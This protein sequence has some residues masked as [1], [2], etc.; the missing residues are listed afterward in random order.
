VRKS[1]AVLIAFAVALAGPGWLMMEKQ[2]ASAAHGGGLMGGLGE[3]TIGCAIL[4][5]MAGVALA[6]KSR[7]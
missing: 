6:W 2:M 5:G 3:L 1:A 7:R 4:L